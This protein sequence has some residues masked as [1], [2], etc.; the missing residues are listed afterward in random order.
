MIEIRKVMDK[1]MLEKFVAFPNKLYK[2]NPYYVP[3]LLIDD[4][5]TLSDEHNPAFDF[6]EAVYFVAF[7]KKKMV[8]RIGGFINH[9]SNEKWNQNRVRFTHFD[10]IDDFEVSK[11]LMEAVT[12]WAKEKGFDTIHGPLGLTDMD[13]QGMLV[14]GYH[15]LDMFI[16]LYNYPYYEN[17]LKELGFEKEIDWVEYQ[18]KLPSEPN[19]I[20]SKLADRILSRKGYKLV[21]FKDKKDILPWGQEIFQLYNDAFAPLFG[22]TELT[23]K[24]IDYYIKTFFGFVNP[25]FIKIVVDEDGK[26]A[27]FGVTMPSLSKALQKAKG[28]I[29]PIG[30]YH[31]LKSIKHNKIL[32]L[33]LIAVRP[34]LQG[35]GLNAV[36]MDSILKT[37]IEY[38]IEYAETGPE[39]ETNKNVQTQWKHFEKRQHRR[40]R[41]FI[42]EL[43]TKE[44]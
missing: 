42:K 25:D 20:I 30:F 34:D 7:K 38:G 44:D 9:K 18:I 40:R 17:H 3:G 26:L 43:N 19:E 29:F 5:H 23:Q 4:Y 6:C 37:A 13:H 33:Y 28:K 12:V 14:E 32:D 1:K 15:E 8:G 36:L 10:F 31:I 27:A 16:T 24:Q 35:K 41:V 2:G 11:K 22:T 39:L 21:E